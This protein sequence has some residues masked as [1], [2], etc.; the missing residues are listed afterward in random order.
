MKTRDGFQEM[1]NLNHRLEC[2]KT[3]LLGIGKGLGKE[4][5]MAIFLVLKIHL[6]KGRTLDHPVLLLLQE[7]VFLLL[8]KD[9]SRYLDFLFLVNYHLYYV[10]LF[11]KDIPVW[12]R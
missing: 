6:R 12:K 11:S 10:S 4:L 5:G 1:E 8:L 2:R 7:L 3:R 9:L